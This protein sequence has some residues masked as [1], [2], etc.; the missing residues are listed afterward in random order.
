MFFCD[1]DD[2]DFASFAD[3]NTSYSRLS[4]MIS[5]LG[6]LKRSIDKIFVWFTKKFIKG[7]ADKCYLI[8]HSK[9]PAEIEMSNITVISKEKVKLLGIYI[10]NILMSQFSYFPLIWMFHSRAIEHRINR[11]HE[12]TLRIIYSNQNQLIFKELLEKRRPLV[13]TREIYKPLQLKFIMLKARS[14]LRL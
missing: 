2:L 12:K 8:T 4:D 13:Y 10:G 1:I 7:N 5:F 14:L 9:T 11:I 6:Q 3:D